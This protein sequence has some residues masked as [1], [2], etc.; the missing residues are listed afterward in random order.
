MYVV[1]W[2][3]LVA[4]DKRAAFERAYGPDGTWVKLF[5]KGTGYL[6]TE[7]LFD[8]TRYL[9]IDRWDSEAAYRQFRDDFDAEYRKLDHEFEN[10]TQEERSVGS[11]AALS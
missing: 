11:F 10:L 1:L 4:P 3:F 6:G 9:T 8:G 2:F 7:L 5:R